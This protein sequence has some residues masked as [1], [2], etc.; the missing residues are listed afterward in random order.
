MYLYIYIHFMYIIDNRITSTIFYTVPW[1]IVFSNTF[2][3]TRLTLHRQA[4]SENTKKFAKSEFFSVAPLLTFH[5]HVTRLISRRNAFSEKCDKHPDQTLDI[6]CTTCNEVTCTDFNVPEHKMD[7]H[8]VCS[9]EISSEIH[10]HYAPCAPS[11]HITYIHMY[12]YI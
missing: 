2:I 7:V 5:N 4:I 3:L 9:F 11:Q 6:F 12:V 1:R 8:S 10:I